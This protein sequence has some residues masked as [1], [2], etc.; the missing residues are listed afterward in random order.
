MKALGRRIV[1]VDTCTSRRLAAGLDYVGAADDCPP[2]GPVADR[3][4]GF[5]SSSEPHYTRRKLTVESSKCI[6]PCSG[7]APFQMSWRRQVPQKAKRS[8]FR[9]K[10]T[11]TPCRNRRP[12]NRI[13]F[14]E[15]LEMSL[16]MGTLGGRVPTPE[17]LLQAMYTPPLA[18]LLHHLQS[19]Q[20]R[21]S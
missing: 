18:M 17:Y 4:H 1:P 11:T 14:L 5:S 2:S 3:S 7:L 16:Y 12:P 19:L 10:Q 9:G 8:N 6:V 21:G 15:S 20:R 13:R